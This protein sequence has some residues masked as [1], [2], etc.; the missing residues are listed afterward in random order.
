MKLKH[1]TYLPFFLAVHLCCLPL[2]AKRAAVSITPLKGT[3]P[4]SDTSGNFQP[5]PPPQPGDWLAQHDE[6]GQTFEQFIEGPRNP[7]DEHRTRIILQP[8]GKFKTAVAPSLKYLQ[9]FTEIYFAMPVTVKRVLHPPEKECSIRVNPYSYTL[10]A[11]ADRLL[12]Y[13]MERIPSGAYCV[14]GITMTDLYPDPLWNFVFGYAT[15]QERVGIFSFARYSPTFYDAMAAPDPRLV[16]LRSC[17]ILAH[18]TAHMFGLAHCIAFKCV[19]NGCNNLEENDAQPIHLCPVCLKKLQHATSF[20]VEKRY[21]ELAAF[22][23]ATGLSA[24]ARW[25][26]NHRK[27]L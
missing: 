8:I 23:A 6:P 9:Q 11:N 13:L 27:R 25:I 4:L 1:S 12:Q 18:E 22:Y 3:I 10:Q 16:F 5:V 19:M 21:S 2:S 7:V 24:Q 15:Y 14:L 26:S 17:K 20:N